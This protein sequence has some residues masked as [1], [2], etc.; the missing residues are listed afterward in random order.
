MLRP[1]APSYGLVLPL[2]WRLPGEAHLLPPF[3]DPLLY[4]R[5][6]GGLE[7]DA[8]RHP[9][10]VP[11]VGDGGIEEDLGGNGVILGIG[12]GVVHQEARRTRGEVD[13]PPGVQLLGPV[14][15]DLGPVDGLHVVL[16]DDD[17]VEPLA[18]GEGEEGAGDVVGPATAHHL[19]GDDAQGH[20]RLY[21]AVDPADG[22]A[23]SRQGASYAQ[24]YHGGGEGEGIGILASLGGEG[25]DG[26]I[27]V[28]YGL[29]AEGGLRRGLAAPHP[30]GEGSLGSPVSWPYLSLDDDL[31][32]GGY[33]EV[34]GLRPHQGHGVPAKASGQIYL[35]GTWHDDG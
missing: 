31:G 2:Y 17:L 20:D 7:G 26:V 12:V 14:L 16:Q 11:P 27:A 25:D 30:F 35:R 13:P 28:G 9:A 29:D 15:H 33:Q 10:L 24:G 32:L 1:Y 8:L 23:H 3:N 21:R 18:E 5:G 22:V 4:L 6:I 19:Q 34:V